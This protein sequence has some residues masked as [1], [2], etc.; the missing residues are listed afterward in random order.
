[1]RHRARSEGCA[2]GRAD[3]ID[4][5]RALLDTLLALG[6]TVER[7]NLY[8]SAFKRL[9]MI[10]AAAGDP[11]AERKAIEGMR[12]HYGKAEEIAKEKKA[13]DLYYPAMNR[14]AAE[15]ALRDGRRRGACRS[16]PRMWRQRERA[17]PRPPARP[18]ASGASWG[19]PS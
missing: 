8:G 9:A 11:V 13:A 6:S 12:R 10:E 5:A 16:G 2:G 14:M 18:P 19:R 4:E 3:Q 7:E 1:M 15:L 17:S